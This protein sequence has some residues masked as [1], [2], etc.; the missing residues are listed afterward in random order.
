MRLYREEIALAMELHNEGCTWRNIAIGLGVNCPDILR[1]TVRRA[2]VHGAKERP[3]KAVTA[4]RVRH[5]K[6]RAARVLA[7]Q[8]SASNLPP[9]SAES[10][11]GNAAR[12]ASG[13][14]GLGE[15]VG[16]QPLQ[17]KAPCQS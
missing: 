8:G 10:K 12:G 3:A 2:E 5:T 13:V 17:A 14:S 16:H 9:I 7:T 1:D 6:S 4:N 11:G 15:A